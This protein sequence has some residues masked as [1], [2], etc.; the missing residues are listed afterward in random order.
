MKL[1][2]N[3]L[4]TTIVTALTLT[5]CSTPP[6]VAQE[7]SVQVGSSKISYGGTYDTK[8]TELI[9]NVNGEPVMKGRFPPYTPTQN[10]SADYKGVKFEA[11][12]YFASV[13]GSRR[14]LV[15]I[16]GGAVQA[17]NGKTSDQCDITVNGKPAEPLLF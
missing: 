17:G 11:S 6:K 7:K 3:I 1:H 8:A 2:L 5:A 14:G 9:I 13:L 15:G 4:A 10:L 16:I 12:C